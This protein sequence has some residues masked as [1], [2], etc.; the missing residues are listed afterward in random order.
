MSPV[1]Q[2]ALPKKR[3]VKL[4]KDFLPQIADQ[5]EIS[6]RQERGWEVS[7]RQLFRYVSSVFPF[8]S[9]TERKGLTNFYLRLKSDEIFGVIR[10]PKERSVQRLV[11]DPVT[12][13]ALG[14][15]M[16]VW[17]EAKRKGED[18]HLSSI[19]PRVASAL[20]EVKPEVAQVFKR[21]PVEAE[22]PKTEIRLEASLAIQIKESEADPV[23]LTK[24][25]IKD[26]LAA[27]K[28][29]NFSGLESIESLLGKLSGAGLSI[30]VIS[31]LFA[32]D[33]YRRGEIPLRLDVLLLSHRNLALVDLVNI[34]ETLEAQ[35]KDNESTDKF[36]KK[37]ELQ[38]KA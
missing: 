21:N 3:D 34:M 29:L 37:Y 38:K 26:H 25:E 24:K 9:E 15:T 30:K 7:T 36:Q 16:V 1:E 33:A 13:L 23:Y 31:T 6:G 12:A 22:Q 10:I 11:S 18:T 27:A 28:K 14:A 4:L 19:Y 32:A 17:L 20:D 2:E 8:N 35:L 5:F